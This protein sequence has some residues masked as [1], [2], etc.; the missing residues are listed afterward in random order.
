[1]PRTPQ[2]VRPA[3]PAPRTSR[4]PHPARGSQCSPRGW[5]AEAVTHTCPLPRSRGQT[6]AQVVERQ[7][8]QRMQNKQVTGKHGTTHPAREHVGV[9]VCR[10]HTDVA[11]LRAFV[12][13]GVPLCELGAASLSRLA[14]TTRTVGGSQ[15]RASTLG[16][17]LSGWAAASCPDGPA[18]VQVP[19]LVCPP[20]HGHGPPP[21]RPRS[22]PH[23]LQVPGVSERP[24]LGLGSMWEPGRGP[25]TALVSQVWGQ[26]LSFSNAPETPQ[27]HLGEP[28]PAG[29]TSPGSTPSGSTLGS[30]F[31][32]Q[33]LFP[34]EPLPHRCQRETKARVCPSSAGWVPQPA[35]RC[36]FVEAPVPC[37]APLKLQEPEAGSVTAQNGSGL[38]QALG[39]Q[40]SAS[41]R[42]RR[43]SPAA[44]PGESRGWGATGPQPKP[45]RGPHGTCAPSTSPRRPSFLLC[46]GAGAS[47]PGQRA[48]GWAGISS[49]ALQSWLPEGQT[50]QLAGPLALPSTVHSGCAPA[51]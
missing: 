46:G 7:P 29:N 36:S 48:A 32:R 24:G 4:A 40:S 19:V 3:P 38:P 35:R 2:P 33:H 5:P 17:S 26:E 12:G 30:T 39:Q 49:Q 20:R 23:T 25:S 50:E 21:P 15:S 18:P 47:R 14:L 41:S 44:T 37:V 27:T 51:S 11:G 22:L 8:R 10:G 1:M 16:S 31:P 13:L 9:S 43:G 28:L 34:R 45:W 6:G 42:L